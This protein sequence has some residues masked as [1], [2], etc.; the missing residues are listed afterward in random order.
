VQCTLG[1]IKG[2]ADGL[3]EGLFAGSVCGGNWCGGIP[4]TMHLAGLMR[5]TRENLSNCNL[6]GL[7]IVTD[8]AAHPIPQSFER[9][10]HASFQSEMI[11]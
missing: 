3:F 11:G 9:L 5:Y 2:P 4:Q 1:G 10:E 8:H 6:E 7:L